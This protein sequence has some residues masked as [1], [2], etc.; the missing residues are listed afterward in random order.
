M[1][2][3]FQRKGNAVFDA[4]TKTAGDKIYSQQFRFTKEKQSVH[5]GTVGFGSCVPMVMLFR[6]Q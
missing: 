5:S 4:G 2:S 6:Q 3:L 1:Y